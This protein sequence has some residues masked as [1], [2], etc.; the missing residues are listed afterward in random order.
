MI[1]EAEDWSEEGI[2]RRL[3]RRRPKPVA[4]PAQAATVQLAAQP[5]E[6]K[7]RTLAQTAERTREE[8]DA[9]MERAAVQRRKEMYDQT[10]N[11]WIEIQYANRL[12]AEAWQS[13]YD[14]QGLWGPMTLASKLD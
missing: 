1:D 7:L 13:R 9:D 4:K 12:A 10:L 2:L 6:V 3:K 8:I 5:A 14:P 11:T